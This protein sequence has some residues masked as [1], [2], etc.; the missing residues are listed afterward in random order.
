MLVC[1][2]DSGGGYVGFI[3]T[4][5]GTLSGGAELGFAESN[6]F[7]S[8]LAADSGVQSDLYCVGSEIVT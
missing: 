7:L 3:T 1:S 8:L 6:M 2:D 4:C 5:V